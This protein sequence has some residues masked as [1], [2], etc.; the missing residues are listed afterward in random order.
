MFNF[1]TVAPYI[2]YKN[3]QPFEW[4]RMRRVLIKSG[5]VWLRLGQLSCVR[6]LQQVNM[7]TTQ[8]V[9]P[10]MRKRAERLEST[11]CL[12]KRKEQIRVITG[13]LAF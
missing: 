13:R 12:R 1:V 9:F 7:S 11:S 5:H 6:R 8:A 3:P 10:D 4:E 2:I